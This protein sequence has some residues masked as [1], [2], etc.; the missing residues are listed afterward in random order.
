MKYYTLIN[1]L[2]TCSSSNPHVSTSGNEQAEDLRDEP[3]LSI[4]YSFGNS[5][6]YVVILEV[7]G[8]GLREQIVFVRN[9]H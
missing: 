3:W 8:S 9:G 2:L 6:L 4:W 7:V 1:N 5:R